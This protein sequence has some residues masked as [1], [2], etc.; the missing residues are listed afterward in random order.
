MVNKDKDILSSESHT[1]CRE[2]TDGDELYICMSESD[3]FW[4]LV[5]IY[6]RVG[7][8]IVVTIYLQLIQ[9]RYMFQSFTVLQCSH[10]HCVQPVASDVA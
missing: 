10:Q 4:G 2:S 8:L 9:N 5:Y 1:R 3:I 6:T 7:T